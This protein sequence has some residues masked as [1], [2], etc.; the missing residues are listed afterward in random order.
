[1]EQSSL[2]ANSI[3]VNTNLLSQNNYQESVRFI[4]ITR[5]AIGTSVIL[6]L[7]PSSPFLRVPS[8]AQ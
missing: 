5:C 6:R 8:V 2:F 7:P 4:S 1:M 3:S